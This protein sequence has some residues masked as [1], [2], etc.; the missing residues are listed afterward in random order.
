MEVYNIILYVVLEEGRGRLS[1]S[2]PIFYFSLIKK[3]L[4]K[5]LGV[6]FNLETISFVK[7]KIVT[8]LPWTHEATF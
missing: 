2:L 4:K 1:R 7:V 5:I 3:N 8:N 6:I